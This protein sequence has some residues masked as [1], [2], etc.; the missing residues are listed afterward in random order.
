MA[1][2]PTLH[3]YARA[4]CEAGR[5]SAAATYLAALR[6][7]VRHATVPAERLTTDHADAYADARPV[8]P[9]TR[10]QYRSAVTCWR[11][12]LATGSLTRDVPGVSARDLADFQAWLEGGRGGKASPIAPLT[13]YAR[14]CD[15]AKIARHAGVADPARITGDHI[16][17]YLAKI[18]D[19]QP[20]TRHLAVIAVRYYAEWQGIDDPTTG[21]KV[22]VPKRQPKPRPT[23]ET[24]LT[25]M[26]GCGNPV[27]VAMTALGAFGGLRIF[28]IVKAHAED[29]EAE[30]HDDMLQL[31]VLGKGTNGGKERTVTLDI[32]EWLWPRMAPVWVPGI[33]TGRLFPQFREDKVYGPRA[34]RQLLQQVARDGGHPGSFHPHTLR[35]YA[36]TAAW[37]ETKDLFAVKAMLGHSDIERTLIYV[38]AWDNDKARQTARALRRR[39]DRLAG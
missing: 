34:A 9:E 3:D 8:S 32:P 19:Q 28:E 38:K 16:G 26:L 1:R 15:V 35:H 6:T 33:T 25:H 2:V 27:V 29:F 4:L 20:M 31:T 24:L 7:I 10:R 5:A 13:A 39:A 14:A 22:P 21:S 37:D 18:A 30:T 12:Y 17:A 23:P 36:A 11:R